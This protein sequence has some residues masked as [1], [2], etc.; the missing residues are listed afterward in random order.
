MINIRS[1]RKALIGDRTFLSV[2]V[3]RKLFWVLPGSSPPD[4]CGEG[5]VIKCGE[6]RLVSNKSMMEY[7]EKIGEVIKIVA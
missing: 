4:R 3:D 1:K 6:L 7:A 2:Y 5:S